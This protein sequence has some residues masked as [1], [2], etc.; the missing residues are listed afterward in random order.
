MWT[1][2]AIEAGV[3][4]ARTV[5]KGDGADLILVNADAKRG[6]IELKLD[7]TNLTCDDGT[8]LLPGRLL[9]GMITAKLQE[10]I[11]GEFELKLEDPRQAA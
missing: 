9:E 6:R 3:E 5:V 4:A 8:C 7:V 1:Q 2:Q 11:E 10:H